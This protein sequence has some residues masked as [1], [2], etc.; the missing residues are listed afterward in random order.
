MDPAW[1]VE[2]K[3]YSRSPRPVQWLVRQAYA[4]ALLA[5]LAATGTNPITFVRSY[6][7]ARG[8]NFS[9]DAHDWLGGYP[10]ET[11]TAA[12]MHDQVSALGFEE[13]LSF[14]RPPAI[15]LFGSGCHEFVFTKI[16]TGV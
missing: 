7:D 6:S 15:G 13:T 2:K 11:A 8:M 1:K 16:G 3:F 9:H 14:P 5:R 10:Y 4:S 12:E